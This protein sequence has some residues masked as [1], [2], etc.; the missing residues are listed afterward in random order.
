M[1][2]SYANIENLQLALLTIDI[3]QAQIKHQLLDD[4]VPGL[5]K[6]I[7]GVIDHQKGRIEAMKFTKPEL[8]KVAGQ[9]V[10]DNGKSIEKLGQLKSLLQG[11]TEADYHSVEFLP[12][13]AAI[14]GNLAIKLSWLEQKLK[15]ITTCLT[16]NK[17][18][19][20]NADVILKK[21]EAPEVSVD[22]L[23]ALIKQH[24]TPDP[25]RP[26][27]DAEASIDSAIVKLG[28]INTIIGE[29]QYS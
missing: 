23:K 14:M 28:A 27:S 18:H 3:F 24:T 9:F 13:R 21:L 5:Q 10:K 2:S 8:Q 4:E 1:L 6:L 20:K 22:T 16:H 26:K 17:P 11:K 29:I 15:D 19:A 12:T 25:Q 7:Q